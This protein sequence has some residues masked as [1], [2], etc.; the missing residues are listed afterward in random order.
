MATLAGMRPRGWRG[1]SFF[2]GRLLTPGPHLTLPP[3]FRL[4]V[5][6]VQ[7]GNTLYLHVGGR[8]AL[9][10]KAWGPWALPAP[11]RVL[12]RVPDAGCPAA[13]REQLRP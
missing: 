7:A 5:F 11:R 2:Q 12:C 3:Y 1:G 13:G 9:A 10:G 4:L 8:R 6:C